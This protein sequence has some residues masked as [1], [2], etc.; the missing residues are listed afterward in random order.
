MGTIKTAISIDSRTF[1]K[2][3]IL[4]RKLRISRSQFF[5][6]AAKHMIK[7]DDNLELLKKINDAYKGE[8]D[9]IR[10]KIEKQYTRKKVVEKW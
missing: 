1:K 5:T 8:D 7:K 9:K 3:D 4:A 6:Q 2:V 10:R